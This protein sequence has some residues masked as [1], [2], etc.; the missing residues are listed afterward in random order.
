MSFDTAFASAFDV[1]GGAVPVPPVPS[2]PWVSECCSWEPDLGCTTEEEWEAFGDDV[3]D[4][5]MALAWATLGFLTGGRVRTCSVLARPC[6]AACLGAVDTYG[7]TGPYIAGGQWLN[8]ACGCGQQG[9]G[10]TTVCEFVLPGPVAKIAHIWQDGA[11]VDPSA[12]RVDNGNRVVR[13]DGDCWPV[14]QNLGVAWDQPGAF[15]VEYVPGID[16]GPAG[17]WVAGILSWEFAKLCS[18]GKC[19]LPS[20]VTAISRQG[21]SMEF[22][23]G[24]FAGGVTGIREVDAWVVAVNPHHLAQPSRVW[25][26]DLRTPRYQS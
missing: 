11:E 7:V 2:V 5:A 3:Q 1:E 20:S 18:G 13:Q 23:E 4:R 8:M 12:Y 19:R 6:K 22:T 10:C 26:P 9:C 15:A 14:C 16:P 21:V 25:S 17:L 24:M